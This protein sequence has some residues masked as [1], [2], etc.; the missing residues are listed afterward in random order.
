MFPAHIILQLSD[1]FYFV[2]K[3]IRVD[4]IN[5][6]VVNERDYMSRFVTLLQHPFG[7]LSSRFSPF[8]STVFANTLPGALEQRFGCDVLLVFRNRQNIKIVCIECK[9]LHYTSKIDDWD[10][11]IKGQASHF[12]SQI[13]RQQQLVRQ[14]VGVSEMLFNDLATRT[15]KGGLDLL[16]S[17]V[18]EHDIA[19]DY[20]NKVILPRTKPNCWKWGDIEQAASNQISGHSAANIGNFI[21]RVLTCTIG[22]QFELTSRTNS[23]HTITIGRRRIEIPIPNIIEGQGEENIATRV[24]EFMRSAGLRVYAI[25]QIS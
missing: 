2:D 8:R 6:R 3:M 23:S 14:G 17:S 18:I 10:S 12:M 16:G 25:F 15:T 5:R 1:F 24:T 11:P 20:V 19:I 4:L 13:D 21:S 9:Y 22:E 7:V